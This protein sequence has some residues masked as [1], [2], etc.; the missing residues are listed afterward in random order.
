MISFRG[1]QF[2]RSVILHAVYFYL[3]YGVSYRD[4]EEILAERGVVVDHSILNRWVV[5]YAPLVA[6]VAQKRKV[7][8]AV[9]WRMD[10]TY[11]N[12]RGVW[13]YPYRA[14][15]RDGQTLDFMLSE[16]RDTKA[17][18]KF[19]AQALSS[20]GIPTQIVIDKNRATAARITAINK[21]L[22]RLGRNAHIDTVRSRYLNDI[23]EQDHRFI[24]RHTRP[25]LGFK[26]FTSAAATLD[27]IE[28]ANMIRKDQLGNRCPFAAFASLAA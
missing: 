24:K 17:A 22:K 25:V 8:T 21:I 12:V 9:S 15:D 3:P 23:V 4:L 20:N 6:L 27:G 26:S 1:A 5:K 19:F 11:M 28:T 2:P 16:K 18:K 7:P 13:M 10:E 14:V